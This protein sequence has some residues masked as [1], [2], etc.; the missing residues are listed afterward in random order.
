[1]IKQSIY[2]ISGSAKADSP[3][4][5]AEPT[6]RKSEAWGRRSNHRLTTHGLTSQPN[7]PQANHKLGA[8]MNYLEIY[9]HGQ[10]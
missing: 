10:V 2:W 6:N 1:M 5:Y 9:W 7:T 4:A 3:D 8:R